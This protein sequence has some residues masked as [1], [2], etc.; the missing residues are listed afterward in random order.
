MPPA[1]H[2]LNTVAAATLALACAGP[3]LA[4]ETSPIAQA[5]RGDHGRHCSAVRPGGG[6][7]AACL[8]QHESQLSRACQAALTTIDVCIEQSQRLC[9][10]TPATASA[11]RTCMQAHAEQFSPACRA[12]LPGR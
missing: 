2:L 3:A 6:R 10:A 7:I 9:G 5:C 1:S 8:K 12:A 4:G 11:L